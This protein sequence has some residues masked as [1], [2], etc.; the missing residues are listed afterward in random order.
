MCLQ[1]QQEG[2]YCTLHSKLEREHT[3]EDTLTVLEDTTGRI[4]TPTTTKLHCES[5][6]NIRKD[7]RTGTSQVGETSTNLTI[8]TARETTRTRNNTVMRY[9]QLTMRAARA[10]ELQSCL[11]YRAARAAELQSCQNC[12]GDQDPG[13]KFKPEQPYTEHSEPAPG[14]QWSNPT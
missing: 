9:S 5:R 6:T 14:T 10:A 4:D 13:S 1:K 8:K 7:T 3:A 11:S 2:Q 12:R